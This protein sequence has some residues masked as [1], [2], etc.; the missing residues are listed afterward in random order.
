[1]TNYTMTEQRAKANID[2]MK[3]RVNRTTYEKLVD[4]LLYGVPLTTEQMTK[5]AEEVYYFFHNN[6]AGHI[7]KDIILKTR[8][9]KNP[10]GNEQKIES[11]LEDRSGRKLSY[12]D[13]ENLIHR[14][15]W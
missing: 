8:Y 12:F 5:T 13:I 1:M 2:N 10:D 15:Y 7:I 11:W 4:S 6:G 3:H 9:R 14:L